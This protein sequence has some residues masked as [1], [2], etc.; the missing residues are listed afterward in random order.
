MTFTDWLPLF[1]CSLD[2]TTAV[3]ERPVG[4]AHKALSGALPA[5]PASKSS[6]TAALVGGVPVSS[7]PVSLTEAVSP[8]IVESS[9][10][11]ESAVELVVVDELLVV[12]ATVVVVGSPVLLE[13]ELEVELDAL[14]G[15]DVVVGSVVVAGDD[16]VELLDVDVEGDDVVPVVE[17]CVVVLEV[18]SGV[19]SNC[20]PSAQPVVT[21]ASSAND[22]NDRFRYSTFTQFTSLELMWDVLAWFALSENPGTRF[23]S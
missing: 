3:A 4:I 22:Q 5:A 15:E 9:A 16:V 18:K 14:V 1:F 21:P 20:A 11:V 2:S 19:D 6:N 8:V 7:T 10:P 23:R 12:V 13:V 17:V